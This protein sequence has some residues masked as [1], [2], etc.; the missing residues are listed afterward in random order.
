MRRLCLV[1]LLLVLAIDALPAMAQA[2][3]V[4]PPNEPVAGRSQADW[5]R[6]WWQLAGSFERDDSPVGDASGAKCGARQDGDV[7]FL[8]GTYGSH[9][10]QRSCRVPPGKFLYFPLINYVVMPRTDGRSTCA[11]VTAGARAMT[12]DVAQLIL[13][14]DGVPVPDLERHRQATPQCFNIAEQAATALSVFPS[15]A[16]G[17]YVMLRPLAPGRH[18]LNFGGRLPSMAQAV[19]YTLLVE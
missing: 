4:V 14:I 16:N 1:S 3:A 8:A 11:S 2:D 10:V 18:V 17:Y 13:D 15:A 7:W 9:R 6:L 19:T 12:D 5:S